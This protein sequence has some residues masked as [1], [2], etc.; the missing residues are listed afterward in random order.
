MR[1]TKG[2]FQKATSFSSFPV[3]P[4][5]SLQDPSIF[6]SGSALS[7][8]LFS[9]PQSKIAWPLEKKKPL[10]AANIRLHKILLVK[11]QFYKKLWHI[12][13]DE[14]LPSFSELTEQLPLISAQHPF[15]S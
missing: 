10:Q 9:P 3:S 6:S 13:L 11:K 12:G 7:C 5:S 14:V 2:A 8:L 15:Q 1:K 4:G